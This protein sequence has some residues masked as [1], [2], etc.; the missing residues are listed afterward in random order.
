MS[1][2]PQFNARP[3][4]PGSG[5]T[6]FLRAFLLCAAVLSPFLTLCVPNSGVKRFGPP[7]NQDG[8]KRVCRFAEQARWAIER[9]FLAYV[10]ARMCS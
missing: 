4:A 3:Q 9:L 5:I 7:V 1:S 10:F 8:E 2:A 6:G